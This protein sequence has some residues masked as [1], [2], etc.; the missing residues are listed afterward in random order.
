[1]GFIIKKLSNNIDPKGKKN[2][3]VY[4]PDIL[5]PETKFPSVIYSK[6]FDCNFN[7]TWGQAPCVIL[8]PSCCK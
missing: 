5:F 2:M 6:L 8:F 7:S 3:N 4:F 1:M